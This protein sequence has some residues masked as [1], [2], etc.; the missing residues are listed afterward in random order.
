MADTY[1][2]PDDLIQLRRDFRQAE[3][4]IEAL[5]DRLPRRPIPMPESY[6]DPHGQHHEPHRGWTDEERAEVD[7]LRARER[8]LALQLA[9]HPWWAECGNRTDAGYALQKLIAD[10]RA[11]AA[12]SDA[13][14]A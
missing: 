12:E 1:N 7:A 5:L 11:G 6:T 9:R 14:H 2:F 4:D 13:D 10:E 8:D 3:A